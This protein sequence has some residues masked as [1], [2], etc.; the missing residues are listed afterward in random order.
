MPHKGYKQTEAHRL[1]NVGNTRRRGVV[2]S[3]EIKKNISEG[4]KGKMVGETHHSWT[5][6]YPKYRTL[7]M[8]VQKW[9]GTPT[10]CKL[11]GAVGNGHKMHWA[12]ISKT[13]KR[14]ITD[15]IRLCVKCHK[16]YDLKKITI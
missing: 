5:G 13:Y 7:H 6:D 1:V 3:E 15:W 4:R 14:D 2:L 9:L 10:E 12:N 11:C 16:N 8:W